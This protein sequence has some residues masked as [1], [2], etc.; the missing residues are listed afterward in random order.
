MRDRTDHS[1]D[2][3]KP[4]D[5]AQAWSVS[6]DLWWFRTVDADRY[7]KQATNAV[8][9]ISQVFGF[10]RCV[11]EGYAFITRSYGGKAGTRFIGYKGD[12]M[13][14]HGMVLL[15]ATADIDGMQQICPWRDLQPTPRARYDNLE[16]VHVPSFT[17]ERLSKFF[18]TLK[19]RTAYS[20]WMRAVILDHMKPGQRALVVCKK[21]THAARL[22]ICLRKV[23]C[24]GGRSRCAFVAAL[25]ASMSTASVAS[26]SLS[27]LAIDSGCWLT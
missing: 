13:L 8:P 7:A 18:L 5:D 2:L 25:G 6:D 3:E 20:Q 19:S 15:D 11:A 26:K 4:T 16:I 14:D 24:S 1:R 22:S 27:V 10:A 9:A 12:L 17:R 23:A 21:A